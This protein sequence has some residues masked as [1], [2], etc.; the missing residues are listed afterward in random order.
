VYALGNINESYFVAQPLRKIS[1]SIKPRNLKVNTKNN[2]SLWEFIWFKLR[3]L[4]S[5]K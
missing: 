3:L 4:S 1:S 2:V 5:G